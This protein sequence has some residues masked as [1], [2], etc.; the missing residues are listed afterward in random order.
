MKLHHFTSEHHLPGIGRFGLTIGDVPTDIYR[1]EGRCGVWLTSDSTAHGHGL[2]GSD[3][4]K[5]R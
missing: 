3:V 1:Y 2:E 4:D 5:S